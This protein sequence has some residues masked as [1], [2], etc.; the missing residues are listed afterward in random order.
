MTSNAK[1]IQMQER[2]QTIVRNH[3]PWELYQLSPFNYIGGFNMFPNRFYYVYH[4]LTIIIIFFGKIAMLM[5]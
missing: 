1:A 5:F 4:F 3:T 2:C